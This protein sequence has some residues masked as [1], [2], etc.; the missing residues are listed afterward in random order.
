M[1]VVRIE[2]RDIVCIDRAQVLQSVA[3]AHV[4]QETHAVNH[5][6][7]FVLLVRS[8]QHKDRQV[9]LSRACL[10]H[11]MAHQSD[12]HGYSAFHVGTAAPKHPSPGIKR[13][14]LQ[15]PVVPGIDGIKMTKQDERSG[16]ISAQKSI[17]ILPAKGVMSQS[18]KPNCCMS[19]LQ[20]IL[21]KQPQNLLCKAYFALPRANTSNIH[22]TSSIT[23]HCAIP[24]IVFYA[25]YHTLF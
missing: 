14:W 11:E 10:L 5:S 15:H 18:I 1:W 13:I 7:R 9:Q 6:R 3:L 22:Q 19:I 17:D 4:Q 8:R 2:C 16:S 21:L 25:V 12:I 20:T 24:G 23:L